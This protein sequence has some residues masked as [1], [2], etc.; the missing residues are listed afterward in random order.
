MLDRG[1]SF[2]DHAHAVGATVAGAT[3]TQGEAPKFWAMRECGVDEEVIE[4][5]RDRISALEKSL[6]EVRAP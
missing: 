6:R 3:D 5:R 1:D 2:I 4:A